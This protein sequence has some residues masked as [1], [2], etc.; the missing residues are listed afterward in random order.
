MAT[1]MPSFVGGQA[2]FDEIT[3]RWIEN[4]IS[5]YYKEYFISYI[6]FLHTQERDRRPVIDQL[7]VALQTTEPISPPKVTRGVARG[8]RKLHGR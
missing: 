8:A 7:Q 5:M 2:E 6:E 1:D 3:R 4:P